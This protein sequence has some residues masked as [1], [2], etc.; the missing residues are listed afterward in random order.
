MDIDEFLEKTLGKSLQH[1]H[2]YHFTDRRNLP[3][4]REHGI[5]S[6]RE[7]RRRSI[8]VV[9]PGGNNWSH[10]ADVYAG[11]DAY[12]HLC[13]F[14]EHPMEW[15]AKKEKRIEETLFLRIDP[16]I[17]HQ[18]GVLITTEVSN[19]SGAMGLA[20]PDALDALDL[21]VIYRRTDWRDTAV[22]ERLNRAKLYEILIPNEVAPTMILNLADG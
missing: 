10:E 15:R 20:V 13:F 8:E 3:K 16:A 14:S 21:E 11:V 22:R 1:R 4:I 7:I 6:M 18:P 17:L 2:L 12:V 5:L 19:K 9:A